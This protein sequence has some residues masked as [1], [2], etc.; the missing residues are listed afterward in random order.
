MVKLDA[1]DFEGWNNLAR[2]FFKEGK[3]D[4]AIKAN[5]HCLNINSQFDQALEFQK[6]LNSCK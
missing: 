2:S 6:T 5:T 3:V 4:D 1:N